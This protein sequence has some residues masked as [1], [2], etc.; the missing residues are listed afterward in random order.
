MKKFIIM[1]SFLFLILLPCVFLKKIHDVD[2]K[3]QNDINKLNGKIINLENE[4]K[5]CINN[6][7]EEKIS[8][9]ESKIDSF[10][11]NKSEKV[12]IF[13]P[14]EN[15]KILDLE[16]QLQD[17][18]KELGQ[19]KDNSIEDNKVYLVY[20]DADGKKIRYSDDYIPTAG[21]IHYSE[22]LS[23]A[24]SNG[25]KYGD[26]FKKNTFPVVTSFQNEQK[27]TLVFDGWYTEKNGKGI[28][29]DKNTIINLNDNITLYAN[30]KEAVLFKYSCKNTNACT[31]GSIYLI[32]GKKIMDVIS[33]F[34]ISGFKFDGI[35]NDENLSEKFDENYEIQGNE[36]FIVNHI[37]INS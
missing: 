25:K 31:S 22:N 30:F 10:K 9:L 4:S 6:N 17:L 36:N 21:F 12:K 37:E 19:E 18:K 2:R 16:N 24:V 3:Y 35:Y 33:N 20:F 15:T 34:D 26:Y 23:I 28:K 1:V 14:K 5:E 7:Y 13:T 27:I 11:N 32:K 29:I 8:E